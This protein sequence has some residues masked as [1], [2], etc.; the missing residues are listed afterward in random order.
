MM[1]WKTSIGFAGALI[2][3]AGG[4]TVSAS[5]SH[6]GIQGTWAVQV[7]LRDCA[8]NA[9]L[10]PPFNSLVTFHHGGT[11]SETTASRAFAPG[12]R[13]PGQGTWSREGARTFGQNMIALIVFDTPP[14]LP[15]TPGF[16]PS[17]PVSPGFLT[18]WSIVNHKVK[19]SADGDQITS[20]GTNEFHKAD[21]TVYRTGCSTAVGQRFE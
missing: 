19:L 17:L 6:Q 15:G 1:N 9:P 20:A 8:T 7:T 16:N 21:D 14:N 5:G 13:S 10:G 2:A 18:G 4:V 12:Q 11:L 3:A